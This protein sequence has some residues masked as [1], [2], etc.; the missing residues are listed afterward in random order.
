MRPGD[1]PS[2]MSAR[3]TGFTTSSRLVAWSHLGPPPVRGRAVL[4]IPAE[5]LHWRCTARTAREPRCRNMMSADWKCSGAHRIKTGGQCE[6]LKPILRYRSCRGETPDPLPASSS[7][8]GGGLERLRL[9]FVWH[10]VIA[11][12][13]GPANSR[14]PGARGA[15]AVRVLKPN[16]VRAKIASASEEAPLIGR[17]LSNESHPCGNFETALARCICRRHH[18]QTQ[19][20]A[21]ISDQTHTMAVPRSR[22]ALALLTSQRRPI[23]CLLCQWHRAFTTTP[24]RPLPE[25]KPPTPPTP[26]TPPGP[27]TPG[28]DAAPEAPKPEPERPLPAGASIDAPRSWGKRVDSFEPKPLPRP[29]GMNTPPLPGENAGLDLRT[30]RERRDDFVNYDRHLIRR[31]QLW[32]SSPPSHVSP[33]PQ[34]A[35]HRTRLVPHHT[36]W[37]TS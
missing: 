20:R 14:V 28:P 26:P 13:R 24:R 17:A 35:S 1:V 9:G 12:A 16:L 22:A 10:C 3:R 29:I 18:E 8:F 7:P 19:R 6:E 31:K 27:Q 4:G 25:A 34:P 21:P 23:T 5:A 11:G 36:S 15:A 33:S 2:P 30:M 37:H 32:V